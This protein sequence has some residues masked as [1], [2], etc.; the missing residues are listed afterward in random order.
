MRRV[1]KIAGIVL[2][3]FALLSLVLIAL[4]FGLLVSLGLEEPEQESFA[5]EIEYSADFQANGTLNNTKF[6][7]PYPES[8]RFR[9]AVTEGENEN[10]SIHNEPNAS[11]SLTNTS[12]G[13]M[14]QVDLGNF[15]PE[16]SSPRPT[17]INE[18]EYPEEIESVEGNISNPI[19]EEYRSYDIVISVDYNR[20]IDTRNGLEVEPH[21]PANRT[22]TYP[23]D[24]PG[25]PECFSSS[26]DVYLS[27]DAG[28]DAYVDLNLDLEGRNSW[29]NLGW[30]GNSYSQRFY[31]SYYEDDKLVGSQNRWFTLTGAETQG[32]GNYRE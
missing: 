9:Q 30:S 27:Y 18:S 10:I 5:H 23:C 11:L 22:R 24:H 13:T 26:T 14:L 29:W 31:T 20:T 8:E 3:S 17:P 19:F 12:R 21:L 32:S 4:L 1:F 28:N 6:L 16:V 7:L 25:E 15:T 2:G